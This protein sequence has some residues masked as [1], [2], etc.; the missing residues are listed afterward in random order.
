MNRAV[1]MIAAL[2]LIAGVFSR[3]R[4]YSA[5]VPDVDKAVQGTWQ[6]VSMEM[7]GKA[8]PKEKIGNVSMKFEGNKV[9]RTIPDGS[10]GKP[11]VCTTD[12]SKTPGWM[13]WKDEAG[14]TLALYEVSGDTLKL[15]FGPD[16]Q[17]DKPSVRPTG[18]DSKMGLLMVL[19]RK[20]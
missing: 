20:K 5:D 4:A 8:L 11:I 9:I 15:C 14:V 7:N 16:P 1:T 3:P 10:L 6:V 19:E 2:G 18:M 13:D 17:P 12:A